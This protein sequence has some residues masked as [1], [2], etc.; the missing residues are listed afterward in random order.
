[1][2]QR[3]FVL[4][5]LSIA[6]AELIVWGVSSLILCIVL[7]F[8]KPFTSLPWGWR[9]IIHLININTYLILASLR[10]SLCVGTYCIIKSLRKRMHKDI[11][12]AKNVQLESFL[13][14]KEIRA[15]LKAYCTYVHIRPIYDC[16]IN[17][18]EYKKL[19]CRDERL[20][21]YQKITCAF[22][23]EDSPTKVDVDSKIRTPLLRVEG[24][25]T[26]RRKKDPRI[27]RLEFAVVDGKRKHKTTQTSTLFTP[28]RGI[29][30]E[31]ETVLEFQLYAHFDDFIR[32][33]LFH[34]A[35]QLMDRDIVGVVDKKAIYRIP[36]ADYKRNYI[37]TPRVL[38]KTELQL[39]MVQL[40]K[41]RRSKSASKLVE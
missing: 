10:V 20:F 36:L 35:V 28:V 4:A 23:K 30:N 40:Q 38:G 21:A 32:Y 9:V 39:K 12:L 29:F 8:V 37:S 3:A 31:L 34:D 27:T 17:I 11:Y 7:F 22:L 6:L 33:N 2:Y 13:R 24:L 1:M 5:N 26:P 25:V 16:L 19:M 15:Y 14:D 41:L 18:R